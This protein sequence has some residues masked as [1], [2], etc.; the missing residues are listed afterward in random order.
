MTKKSEIRMTEHVLTSLQR[1]LNGWFALRAVLLVVVASGGLLLALLLLDAQLDLSDG[2]R[3][4]APALLAGSSV[5]VIASTIWRLRRLSQER[6]AR[7]F[8]RTNPALG[9]RL[10]NAVQLSQRSED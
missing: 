8:E 9:N 1:R 6:V 3:A 7:L 4:S 2:L 5:A 10:I